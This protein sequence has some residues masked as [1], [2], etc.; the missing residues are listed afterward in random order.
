MQNKPNLL[1]A[2]MNANSCATKAYE[3]K[4]QRRVRKNKA[5]S[6]PNKPNLQKAK[7]NINSIITKDYRKKDDFAVQKNKPNSN[8]KQTQTKPVLSAVEWANF[9]RGTGALERS[10]EDVGLFLLHRVR[11]SPVR[12]RLGWFHREMDFSPPIC[13]PTGESASGETTEYNDFYGF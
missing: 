2:Q 10:I 6:N 8:P 3:N 9:K 5:N 1:D 7:M 13:S 12:R 11:P 4:R